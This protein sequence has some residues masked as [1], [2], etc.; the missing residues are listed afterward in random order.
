MQATFQGDK[1]VPRDT[2]LPK[3]TPEEVEKREAERLKDKNKRGGSAGK[4]QTGAETVEDEM[5]GTSVRKVKSPR[6]ANQS[7]S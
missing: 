3:P 4:V 2:K 1:I 6:K 7:A 5:F